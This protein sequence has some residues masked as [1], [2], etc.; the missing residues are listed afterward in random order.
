M[1]VIYHSSDSFASVTGVSMLSL[2]ENN[3]GM[4]YIH[5]LYIESGITQENKRRLRN[6]AEQYGRELEFMKM[7][8]WSEKLNIDLKS[9]KKE[10]HGLGYNR[11]FLTEYLPPDV[12]RVLYLDSDTLIE[13]PLNKLWNQ[14]LTGYYLAGVDD[15]LS[16]NY[17]NLVGLGKE[18]TYVN[19]GVLLINV[20]KWRE[21]RICQR[22]IDM[23]IK[24]NGFFIFN[25]QTAI[26]A[27]FC[28]KIKILP[29]NY[30]VNSLVYLYDFDELMKLRKPYH[31]SYTKEDLLDAKKHPIITH[32]TGNFYVYRRPWAQNSDHPHAQAFLKYREMSPWKEEALIEDAKDQNAKCCNKL[33][34]MLPRRIMIRFV[35]FLYNYIRIVAFTVKLNRAQNRCGKKSR[36]SGN[37]SWWGRY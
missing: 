30:N 17:R 36:L 37:N 28:G 32:Y 7:P 1:Y 11:L 24:N 22:F 9:S 33:C 14:D 26:N 27:L 31:Y 18:G 3:K 21:D 2:F 5:V 12:D 13:Q 34:H 23:I 35:S 16:S 4:D 8:D 20:E 29:Q 19:S 6:I 25:E 10:W 15:C